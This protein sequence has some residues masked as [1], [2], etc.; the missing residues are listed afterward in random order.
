MVYWVAA[1]GITGNAGDRTAAHDAVRM[2]LAVD[3]IRIIVITRAEIEA[4]ASGADLIELMKHRLCEL[5]V[6]GSSFV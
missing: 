2:A 1:N 3:G 4:L 6:A 5:T